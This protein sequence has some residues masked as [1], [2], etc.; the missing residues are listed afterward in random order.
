MS[1]QVRRSWNLRAVEA[2]GPGMSLS[3]LGHSPPFFQILQIGPG[4]DVSSGGIDGIAALVEIV[5][6]FRR[7]GP[8]RQHR[9]VPLIELN[10]RVILGL[11]SEPARDAIIVR[12]DLHGGRELVGGNSGE[13]HQANVHGAGID[14]LTFGAGEDGTAFV[15][16][17]RQ[18]H[19]PLQLD[20]H[21]AG[22]ILSQIHGMTAW[23]TLVPP[24]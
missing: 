11:A 19:V 21:T 15:D 16:H 10:G 8:A 2:Y 6:L 23:L 12:I 20:P 14:V 7:A 3:A 24:S 1:G 18:M 5:L 22:Q 17:A 13:F 4:G 9:F